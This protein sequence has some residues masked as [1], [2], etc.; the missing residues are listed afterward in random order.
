M[1]TIRIEQDDR[2]VATLW[3]ARPEKRNAMSATMIA[4]LTSAAR[5]LGAASDM[6]AVVLAA[7]GGVF[8]AG[9]D[10][11]WMQEQIAADSETRR[12]EATSLAMMLKALNEMPKPLIARVDGNAFGGGLGLMSVADVVVAVEGTTFGLTE[13]RL[14]LIPATIG[15][16]VIARMGEARARRVFFSGRLFGADEARDLG[17]VSTVFSADDLDAAVEQEVEPYFLAAPGAVAAAKEV[18]RTL[19]P[20]VGEAE[21]AASIDALVACWEGDEAREGTEAFFAKRRANWMPDA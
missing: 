15:P 7:E 16:Y 10:L 9:G 20:N 8:C 2:G 5:D 11:A 21:I 14:G 17:L 1:K 13:T 4:E 6:R 12:R 19:G 3:L 18:V